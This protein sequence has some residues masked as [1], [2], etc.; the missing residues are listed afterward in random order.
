[1]NDETLR[2]AR[3][4]HLLSY[5]G[6]V[7]SNAVIRAMMRRK[8]GTFEDLIIGEIE[9]LRELLTDRKSVV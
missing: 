1:M 5:Q 8:H 2:I 6:M 4:I 3:E 9:E 7:M